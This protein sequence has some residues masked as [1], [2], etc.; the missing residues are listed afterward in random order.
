[1]RSV[2]NEIHDAPGV[3]HGHLC[4]QSKAKQS[5]ACI[6]QKP[7]TSSPFRESNRNHL[8]LCKKRKEKDKMDTTL[9]WKPQLN[10]PGFLIVKQ[11]VLYKHDGAAS[12]E[13]SAAC[14]SL[15]DTSILHYVLRHFRYWTLLSRPPLTHW[16]ITW[17]FDIY[18][19]FKKRFIS[20]H[21]WLLK[22][23]HALKEV[24]EKREDAVYLLKAS[25]CFT[26]RLQA[27]ETQVKA[28]CELKRQTNLKALRKD[29]TW[30]GG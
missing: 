7:L 6:R 9:S 23:P 25:F 12:A 29:Y 22:Y 18:K 3:E 19:I 1:M 13:N 28:I 16:L 30:G 21:I 11:T 15:W 4:K 26:M 14:Y 5:K 27:K 20:L 8:P 10:S 17:F 24:K 2:G